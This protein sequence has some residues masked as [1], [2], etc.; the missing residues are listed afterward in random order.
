MDTAS[1]I[2]VFEDKPEKNRIVTQVTINQIEALQTLGLK[3]LGANI[4][5]NKSIEQLNTNP[6]NKP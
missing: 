6:L 3:V 5:R 2:I 1:L 4:I